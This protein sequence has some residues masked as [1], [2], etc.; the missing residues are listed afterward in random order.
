MSLPLLQSRR[1]LIRHHSGGREGKIEE[2]EEEEAEV[3][4]EEVAGKKTVVAGEEGIAMR[5]EEAR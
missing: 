2:E 1:T 5:R 4:V 3:G